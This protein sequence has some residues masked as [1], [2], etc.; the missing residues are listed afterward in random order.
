MLKITT[1][2]SPAE[3]VFEVEGK[4]VGPWIEELENCWRKARSSDRPVKVMLC[5][6]TFIDDKGRDLLVEMYR[7][8]AELVAEG[9]MNTAIVQEIV[10]EGR[11]E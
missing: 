5:A 4:L 3:T 2:A 6:V 11:H 8:G 10:R 1:Q 7:Q 9:C